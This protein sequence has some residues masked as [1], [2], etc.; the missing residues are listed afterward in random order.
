VPLIGERQLTARLRALEKVSRPTGK[1]WQQATIN[2]Y[3]PMVP[4]RTGKLRGSFRPGPIT[5]QH[6]EVKGW[7]TGF[8]IDKG[9]KA[10]DIPKARTKRSRR[11]MAHVL[12]F[13]EGG[14]TVFARR[15]HHRGSAAHPFRERGARK[16]LHDARFGG[17]ITGLWNSAA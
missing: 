16:G 5:D 3:R 7:Y 9:T 13:N 14:G 10:H 12:K 4:V 17:I 15:V 11:R 8:F 1:A 2:A 6:A